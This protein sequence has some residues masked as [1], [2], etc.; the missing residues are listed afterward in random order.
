MNETQGS[1][2][3]RLP[4]WAAGLIVMLTTGLIFAVGILAMSIMERRW[5]SQRPVLVLKPIAPGESDNAVWG[6]NYPEEYESFLKT[7][8]T[9][10]KTKYGGAFPRDYLL[11]D[12]RKV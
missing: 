4:K 2:R 7:R 12:P 5:E 8:I 6:Q 11:E 10:T 3:R 1:Q 9:D